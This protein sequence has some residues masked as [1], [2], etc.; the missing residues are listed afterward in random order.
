MADGHKTV[1]EKK[2]KMS[3]QGPTQ[4][5]NGWGGGKMYQPRILV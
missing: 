1:M 2:K 4:P 3:P 5:T